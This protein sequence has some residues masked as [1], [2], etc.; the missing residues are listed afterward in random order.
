MELSR[1]VGRFGKKK[2]IITNSK[3]LDFLMQGRE[4][5]KELLA[6]SEKEAMKLEVE[7]IQAAIATCKVIDQELGHYGDVAI[8]MI[9][10]QDRNIWILEVNNH[11]Y[12]YRKHLE[13]ESKEAN[14]R[15]RQT[16]FEYAKALCGFPMPDKKG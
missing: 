6:I 8:D 14:Q 13:V 5:L 10:D 7:M 4:A 16:P 2:S 9:I 12:G 15:V 11:F 1:F 3:F